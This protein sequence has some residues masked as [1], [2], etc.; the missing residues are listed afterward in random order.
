MKTEEKKTK[1]LNIYLVPAGLLI[2]IVAFIAFYGKPLAIS[3]HKYR[4][5]ALFNQEPTPDP[6]SGL[7]YFGEKWINAF[8]KH[9]DKLIELGYLKTKD[10]PLKYVFVPSIQSRR[11]WEELMAA[12]PD[13]R[14]TAM[15][16]YEPNIPD[17]ITV[18]DKP[19][20]LPEWERIISAHDSPVSNVLTIEF[21]KDTNELTPYI[22][23]WAY[24]GEEVCY[25][26]VKDNEGNLIIEV[27]SNKKWENVIKNLSLEGKA[28]TFDQFNYI[29]PNEGY[30]TISNPSGENPFSGVRCETILKI[31]PN[32]PNQLMESMS[33]IHTKTPIRGVLKRQQ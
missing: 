1:R 33:T 12:F 30:K 14:F 29:E 4:I 31:N 5:N 32:N 7:A 19:S 6:D 22:G 2:V 24:E 21:D 18:I 20:R 17:L 23:Q 16:G 3:Y 10:F 11:L 26:I 9:R 28:I 15:K 27:P 8:D 13:N 25:I